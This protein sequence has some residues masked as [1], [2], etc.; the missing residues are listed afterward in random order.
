MKNK[1]LWKIGNEYKEDEYV[2]MTPEI[3]IHGGSYTSCEGYIEND[4]PRRVR[5][6]FGFDSHHVGKGKILVKRETLQEAHDFFY[7]LQKKTIIL[8]K[9]LAQA[10]TE[11]YATLS[12]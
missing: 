4:A 1:I 7:E 5:V 3:D 2:D 6:F 12:I 9:L 11:K 10:N 8:E